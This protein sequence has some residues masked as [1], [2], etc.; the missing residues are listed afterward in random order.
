MT[1]AQIGAAWAIGL[2][3]LTAAA[4]APLP[5]HVGSLGLAIIIVGLIVGGADG[6]LPRRI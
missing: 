2:G 1:W 3:C 6:T 4:V 5:E